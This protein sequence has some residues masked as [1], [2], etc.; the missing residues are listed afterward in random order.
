MRVEQHRRDVREN[1]ARQDH[2]GHD[3]NDPK[4]GVA[5]SDELI[6]TLDVMEHAIARRE[7]TQ[8]HQSVNDNEE[9]DNS[10]EN[11]V[12]PSLFFAED[13]ITAGESN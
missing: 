5:V 10:H 1:H 3:L 4:R 8:S 2:S 12:H 9:G 6:L 13:R 11:N 7:A